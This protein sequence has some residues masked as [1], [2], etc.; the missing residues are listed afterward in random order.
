LT[1]V[2][3]VPD[4]K[5]MGL[6]AEE[7]PVVYIPYAQKTQEWLAWTT[8]LIRTAGDPME[9][10]PSVRKAIRELDPNQPIAEVG[11]LEESLA[12][13]TALPRFTTFIIGAVSGVALLIAVVGVYGLLAYSVAQ[14]MAEFG[15]RMTLGASPWSVFWMVLRQALVRVAAGIAG[16]CLAGWWLARLLESQLFEVRPRDPAAFGVAACVLAVASLAA[17]V[18]PV[19]RAMRIDPSTALRGD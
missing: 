7:G 9:V 2:G 8:L 11:T 18:G 10:A 16:G 17:V 3:V 14:R 5:H 19:L 13:S 4:V 1:V 15:I 6:K 12:R